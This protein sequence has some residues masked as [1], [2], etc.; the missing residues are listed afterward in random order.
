MMLS[1]VSTM[2]QSERYVEE[3]YRRI[4]A[5][6]E[7]ITGDIEIIFVN[8]GSTDNSLR[9]AVALG[10]TNSSIRVI[11]LSRNFGHHKAMMTGL[12]HAK[13]DLVFLIDVDLE[14]PP[15][16]LAAFYEALTREKADVAYGIQAPRHGPWLTRTL[17]N[18]FYAFFEFLSD[19]SI[20]QHSLTARLMTKR[21]VNE[22]VRFKEH[23]SNMIGLWE[24][25]GFKQVG[26][27]VR[28]NPFK[29]T[30]TYTFRRK[31][32]AAMYAITAFS[33]KPL[34][35]IAYLGFVMTLLCALYVVELIIEYFVFGRA[36][37]GWT[38]LIVS[39]WLLGGIILFCLGIISTYLAVIFIET[40]ARPY[41]V[42][43]HIY[44]AGA[45]DRRPL[46]TDSSPGESRDPRL[47]E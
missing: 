41:T 42:I 9:Q 44:E 2:Y 37:T 5:E 39:V 11:D 23:L 3:F 15:E 17:A 26:V 28:K 22:L 13:G 46:P 19:Y 24:L 12:E 14:E 20:P 1:V 32:A 21:Y 33:S 47:G 34:R 7:K 29:G 27:P 16:I 6:A 10:Q 4:W 25:A 40:K 43:R 30:T 31:M 35:Y 36:P 45:A 18:L 8:D 38:S